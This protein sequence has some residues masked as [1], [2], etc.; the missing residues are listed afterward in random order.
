MNTSKCLDLYNHTGPYVQTHACDGSESQKWEYN[1]TEHT[2]KNNG[3]CL[4][5]LVEYE[6]V[7]VW[8]GNLSDGAYAVLLINRASYEATVEITWKEIG[9]KEENATL[10][11]LWEKTDLG[12]FTDGYNISLEPHDSLMLKVTPIKDDDGSDDKSD[13][14]SDEGDDDD[15]D[16]GK[17]KK[18]KGKVFAILGIVFGSLLLLLII[19]L[20]IYC[21][22][23]KRKNKAPNTNEVDDD[24]LIDSKRTTTVEGQEANE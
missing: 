10:R 12:I 16:D 19:I 6:S 13:D 20:I 1:Q 11:D 14:E 23:I 5:S 2:L 3:K 9:F 8:A 17:G 15:D 18:G 4:S 24:K 21:C 7:E 22:I